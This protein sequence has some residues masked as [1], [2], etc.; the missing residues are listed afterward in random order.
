LAVLSPFHVE[1]VPAHNGERTRQQRSHAGA[2][3]ANIERGTSPRNSGDRTRALAP[4]ACG[5]H[6]LRMGIHREGDRITI[7]VNA[8][9][10]MV[11]A[12]V[13]VGLLG[14]AGLFVGIRTVQRIHS[15]AAAARLVPDSTG[16]AAAVPAVVR[17]AGR[18]SRGPGDAPVTIVE[19][20]DYECPFCRRHATEI[21]P[22]ALARYGDSV[23]YVVRNFQ[24]AA[25]HPLA[26][27]AA[28]AA[29]CAYR[30]GRFWEYHDALLRETGPLSEARIRAPAAAVGLDLTSFEQCRK[31]EDTR[32]AV[33]RD[34]LDG[35]E[36]GVAGTPTLFVNG[37]RLRGV[38]SAE[39]LER[40][41][42]LALKGDGG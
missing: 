16:F 9:H 19:F 1:S 4:A 42:A 23:R 22:A 17:T 20:T 13:L 11:L 2:L 15:S 33:A 37:R 26:I 6:I 8:D 39:E 5:L 32:D 40:Y 41:I 7:G 29:E 21:L 3:A 25:L 31:A 10:A 24:L 34:L 18:P 14:G 27:A 28:E 35:W 36:L 38:K 12:A 30:Q